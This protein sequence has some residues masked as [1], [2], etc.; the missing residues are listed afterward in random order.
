[1]IGFSILYSAVSSFVAFK[2]TSM[3]CGGLRVAEDDEVEGLDLTSHGEPG[4]KL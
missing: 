1:M 4:Y 3:V 2:L